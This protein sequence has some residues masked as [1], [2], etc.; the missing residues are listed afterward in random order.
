MGAK[1]VPV[2]A[3][4]FLLSEP[5]RT[6]LSPHPITEHTSPH[7]SKDSTHIPQVKDL[8]LE[9]QPP[10]AP[11]HTK[12]PS[13][14]SPFLKTRTLQQ[15]QQQPY[16]FPAARAADMQLLPFELRVLE[17]C[18]Y[19]VREGKDEPAC[20]NEMAGVYVSA[21]RAA[22]IQHLSFEC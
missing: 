14:D 20:L 22:D 2:K 13:K 18:L 10:K 7:G 9:G 4:S 17:L 3:S 21:S 6:I 11:P 15:K 5:S 1:P 19:E 16:A 8:K 12:H